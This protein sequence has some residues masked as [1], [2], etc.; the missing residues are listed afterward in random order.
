[1]LLA[2]EDLDVTRI[3]DYMHT[4]LYFVNRDDPQGPM[5]SNPYQDQQ[6]ENWEYAVQAW[7]KQTYGF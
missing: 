3:Y 5:P 1:M 7:K 2:C 6:F 4:I